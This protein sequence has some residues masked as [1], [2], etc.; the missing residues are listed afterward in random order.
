MSYDAAACVLV[1]EDNPDLLHILEQLLAQ[2]YEVV[3]ARRGEEGV[4]LAQTVR[5][6][7]VLLDLQLPG[8][9]GIEA[10]LWIKREMPHVPILVLTAMIGKGE[11]EMVLR[12]GCCDAFMAKPAPLDAIRAKVAE[13]IGSA[14]GATE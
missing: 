4:A 13:L 5:P 6:D 3:T 8:M 10:G 1:I 9:D 2:E 14:S 11:P 7:L 12:S